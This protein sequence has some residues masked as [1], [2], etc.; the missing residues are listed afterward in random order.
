MVSISLIVKTGEH[1]AHNDARNKESQTPANA[2]PK[3]VL[4]TKEHRNH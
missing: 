3:T 2:D 4:L 1:G